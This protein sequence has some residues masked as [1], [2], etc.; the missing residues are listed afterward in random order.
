MLHS[1]ISHEPTFRTATRAV[2]LPA[3]LDSGPSANAEMEAAET[4]PNP[5]ASVHPIRLGRVLEQVPKGNDLKS[6]R[7]EAPLPTPMIHQEKTIRKQ[8]R[9]NRFF[10]SRAQTWAGRRWQMAAIAVG[11]DNSPDTERSWVVERRPT[12]PWWATGPRGRR[13]AH[14]PGNWDAP[15]GWPRKAARR[16]GAVRRE[17]RPRHPDFG[18]S[19]LAGRLLRPTAVHGEACGF[20]GSAVKVRGL[21][22]WWHPTNHRR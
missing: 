4:C 17:R 13:S 22:H 8:K 18:P 1:P 2:L 10:A 3:S 11:W 15:A 14:G 12:N 7:E 5:R 9:K 16:W 19:R 21:P 6:V 20:A